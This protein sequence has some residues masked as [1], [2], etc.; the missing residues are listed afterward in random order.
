MKTMPVIHLVRTTALSERR[1]CS[2]A[3]G[4]DLMQQPEETE[5]TTELQPRRSPEVHIEA[6]EADVHRNTADAIRRA[7]DDLRGLQ[8]V[9]DDT[10]KRIAAMRQT[11]SGVTATATFPVERPIGAE[12]EGPERN[13]S[14]Q[15][16]TGYITNDAMEVL[17]RSG[18]LTSGRG[19]DTIEKRLNVSRT[20]VQVNYTAIGDVLYVE[21]IDADGAAQKFAVPG[22]AGLRDRAE[23]SFTISTKQEH[24]SPTRESERIDPVN[25]Y[26]TV[27]IKELMPRL[28]SSSPLAGDAITANGRLVELLIEADRNGLSLERAGDSVESDVVAKKDGRIVGRSSESIND[29]TQWEERL[30]EMLHKALAEK[31]AAG[32]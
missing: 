29:R 19:I 21:T 3:G 30:A 2:F 17:K 12:K 9:A 5:R 20:P 23:A 28:A 11:L 18:Y 1:L 13:E 15:Q 4:P 7:G 6:I 14:L 10:D 27:K 8:R 26:N 22:N 25:T 24:A 16:S 31:R 32:Q